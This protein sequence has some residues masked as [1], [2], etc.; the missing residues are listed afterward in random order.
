MQK[1]YHIFFYVPV[2]NCEEVKEA[3]FQAG[4]GA[5]GNY[6]KCSWQVLGQGQFRPIKDA[7]PYIGEVDKLQ[8][9]QEYRVEMICPD[10]S[11]QDVVAAM[12]KSHPYEEVAYGVVALKE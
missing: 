11:L 2:Q 9:V 8:R 10:K 5:V 6:E 7:N 12:K 4:A 3:M 1:L